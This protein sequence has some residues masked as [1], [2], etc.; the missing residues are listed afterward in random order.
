MVM[1][2]QKKRIDSESSE[3]SDADESC[4]TDCGDQEFDAFLLVDG[5]NG[6]VGDFAYLSD[7][8]FLWDMDNYIRHGEN[9]SGISVPQDSAKGM[10]NITEMFENSLIRT[11]YRKL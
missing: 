11:L 7:T 1:N 3:F 4:V 8:K 5:D 2:L 9:F 6:G 10:T